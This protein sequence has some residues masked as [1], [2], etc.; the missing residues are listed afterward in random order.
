MVHNII[1]MGALGNVKTK[2]VVMSGQHCY[3]LSLILWNSVARLKR[4]L[5]LWRDLL[6][7]SWQQSCSNLLFLLPP[8]NERLHSRKLIWFT[9]WQARGRQRTFGAHFSVK[10]RK[11]KTCLCR[12]DRWQ[13]TN[14]EF[15]IMLVWKLIVVGFVPSSHPVEQLSL[16][17]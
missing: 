5:V 3:I 12:A 6:Q 8:S 16:Y 17:V 10:E 4:A 13:S 7:H 2:M 9:T 11:E 1:N 14:C 15:K